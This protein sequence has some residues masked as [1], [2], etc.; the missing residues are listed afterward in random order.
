MEVSCQ[1]QAPTA[2][3]PGKAPRCPL[4]RSLG[5]PVA[6]LDT[7][8]KEKSIVPAGKQTP[9]VEP[10]ARRY[11]DAEYISEFYNLISAVYM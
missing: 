4:D 5:E 10:V 1:L 9:A 2:L 6:S 8:E 7:V 11:N 3:P